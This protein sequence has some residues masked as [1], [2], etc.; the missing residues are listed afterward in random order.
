MLNEN[1]EKIINKSN[2]THGNSLT[3]PHFVPKTIFEKNV[4]PGLQKDSS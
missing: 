2:E 3:N 4:S 1:E